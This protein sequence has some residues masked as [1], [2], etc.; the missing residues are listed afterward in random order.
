MLVN[1]VANASE[2]IGSGVG[3]VTVRTERA[4]CWEQLS[5]EAPRTL[6]QWNE[7]KMRRF[8]RS[9]EPLPESV[10]AMPKESAI[11]PA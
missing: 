1:L 4:D 10:P 6:E 2:A 11:E 8:G 9:T 5:A 7:R 3:V